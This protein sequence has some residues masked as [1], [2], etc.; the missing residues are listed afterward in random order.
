MADSG[1]KLQKNRSRMQNVSINSGDLG[2][3]P[4]NYTVK[5]PMNTSPSKQMFSFS[6]AN[7]FTEKKL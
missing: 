6:K 7:R 3:N 2:G 1:S 4:P 5:S